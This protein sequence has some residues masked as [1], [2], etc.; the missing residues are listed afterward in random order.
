MLLPQHRIYTA[1]KVLKLY[2]TYCVPC[3]QYAPVFEK[4][5]EISDIETESLNVETEEGKEIA[6][7]YGVRSVP[8]TVVVDGDGEILDKKTGVLSIVSLKELIKS[9]TE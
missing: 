4:F 5:A 3:K 1:V 8:T 6:A 2:G 9:A 7:K